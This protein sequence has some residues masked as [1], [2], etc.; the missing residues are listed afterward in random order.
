MPVSQAGEPRSA[1]VESLRAIAALAVL[2]GHAFGVASHYEEATFGD[3]LPLSGGNGVWLFFVL[4]GFLLYR[5]FVKGRVNLKRYA[6]NRALRILPLY[7]GVLIVLL[8]AN[9]GAL[10]DWLRFATFT[11]NFS[12]D[13]IGKVDGPM[14]SLVV[15]L[16]FYL[17]LPFLPRKVLPWLALASFGIWWHFVHSVAASDLRWAWSLPATLYV[18]IL[19]MGLA[20]VTARVGRRGQIALIAA[21]VPFWLLAADRLDWAQPLGGIGALLVVA[22]IV[23]GPPLLE[24]RWLAT[25]GIASYSLYLWHLPIVESLGR[26]TSASGVEL[27]A[28]SLAVCVPIAL[29]SYAL[30]ERP[31]LR[32]RRR[33]TVFNPLPV[34]ATTT[35]PDTSIFDRAATATADV[36]STSTPLPASES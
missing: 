13:T 22:A 20:T 33:W 5:P 2:G 1:G 8:V 15:E 31:F 12:T 24:F 32:L 9:G 19:G 14:W 30:I 25:L 28:I 10:H 4:S 21:S 6:L 23:L 34:A 27:L 36:S 35:V 11:Q 16:Q 26:R 18:F 7:Y 17:L 29:A 3:R